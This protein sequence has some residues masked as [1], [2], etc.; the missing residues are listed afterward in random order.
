MAFLANSAVNRV[1]LHYGVMALAQSG[2]GVF[3]VVFL[4]HVGLSVPAALATIAAIL[5]LRFAI[6]P[7]ILPLARRWGVKPVLIAGTL[8]LALQY[9]VLASVH[10]IG[11]ALAALCVVAAVGDV[12]YW[13]SYNA[14]FASIGDAEHRG[15]QISAREALVSVVGI[16]APLM[17]AW[18]LVTLGAREM[19]AAVGV[20]QALAA[21]PLIGAPNVA[22]KASAPGAFR[23]AR[24][25]VILSASDGW[26]DAC[27]FFVWQ[28][29]LFVSLGSSFSAYGGA[30]A[31]AALVGAA[32]G[33]LL[34][35]HIDAGHGRRA[36]VIACGVAA[37]VVLMRAVSIGSPWLAVGANALGAVVGSLILPAFATAS[38]NMAKASPCPMRFHIATEAGWDVGCSLACLAAAALSASGVPLSAAILLALPALAL[39]GLAARRYYAGAPAAPIGAAV[40]VGSGGD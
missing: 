6:R 21:L 23:A 27:F 11:W 12:L 5:A 28:I 13:P 15:H 22:V 33:L 10:G 4:L 24:L 7:A 31:L 8:F 3:F 17:G 32:C 26:F 9:Q 29:A 39:A 36:L 37:A 38:Y 34:G 20:V 40:V 30:M 18:A 14:Y 1:N 25:G 35:R 16:V 19:F 2:G